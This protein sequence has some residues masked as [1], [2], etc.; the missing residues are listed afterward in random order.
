MKYIVGFLAILG[1][2]GTLGDD[3]SSSEDTSD[4][5][6][7]QNSNVRLQFVG[8]YTDPT[9]SND[10][11]YEYKLHIRNDN[12]TNS[13][14]FDEDCSIYYYHDDEEDALQLQW[15][16]EFCGSDADGVLSDYVKSVTKAHSSDSYSM[17]DTTFYY[18]VDSSSYLNT[19]DMGLFLIVL[20]CNCE[21]F[22]L[23]SLM[24]TIF[25]FGKSQKLLQV[26]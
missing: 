22:V 18:T 16:I 20:N 13:H 24:S 5:C 10:E 26:P 17:D 9:D 4:D 23:S 25:V 8:G 19:I 3:S 1:H 11:C 7:I 2:I 6:S 15:S 14:Y 21:Y 12:E